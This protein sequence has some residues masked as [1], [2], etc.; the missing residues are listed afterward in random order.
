MSLVSISFSLH[1]ICL[2]FLLLFSSLILFLFYYFVWKTMPYDI[3]EFQIILL[4]LFQNS[5][6]NCVYRALRKTD[7][8]KFNKI[9]R[10]LILETC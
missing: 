4:I 7:S 9:I 10:N 5:T 2:A 6:S 8:T 1:H 3:E